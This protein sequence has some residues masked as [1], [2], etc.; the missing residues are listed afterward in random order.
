MIDPTVR[1]YQL[2]HYYLLPSVQ[3]SSL[4]ERT[5][6][7][8]HNYTSLPLEPLPMEQVSECLVTLP[9]ATG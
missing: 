3:L 1:L 6:T 9:S 4:A 8:S 2:R 7:G 5:D